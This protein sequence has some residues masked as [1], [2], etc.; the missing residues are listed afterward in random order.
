M[1]VIDGWWASGKSVLRGLLDGHPNLF[2]SPIQDSVP[3]MATRVRLMK[4]WEDSKD[5]EAFREDLAIAS[6]YYRLERYANRGKML[7]GASRAN[8]VDLDLNIDFY[9]L[10]KRFLELLFGCERWDGAS[11]SNC[12]FRAMNEVWTQYP[13]RPENVSC[14]VT[15]DN[16]YAEGP[17]YFMKHRPDVKMVYFMRPPEGIIATRVGRRSFSND[18]RTAQWENLSVEGLAYKGEVNR[19]VKMQRLVRDLS[20]QYP[21]R[22]MI[23]GFEEMIEQYERVVREVAEFI[24]IPFEESLL[25]FSFCGVEVPTSNGEKYVGKVN[26]KASQ[27]LT[28]EQLKLIDV[29]GKRISLFNVASHPAIYGKYF[30]TKSKLILK[31][32]RRRFVS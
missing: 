15:M 7:S 16:N 24:S 19:I 29:L 25:E 28:P 27:L 12:F 21:E 22:L 13:S 5:V 20:K 14:H 30:F 18:Y 3:S 9:L 1:L 23:I 6:E 32:A 31:H 4:H 11:V 2:V 17:E 10:D 8:L 26:D